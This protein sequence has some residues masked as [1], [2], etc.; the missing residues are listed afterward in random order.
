M[1]RAPC[2]IVLLSAL[3]LFLTGCRVEPEDP[4]I[5]EERAVSRPNI[6]IYLVDT[7]RAD[8]LG[9]YGYSRP[10][11]PN[12]DAFAAEATLFENAI[13]QSS[14]TRASMAS[15]FTGVWP[16]THGATG[17]KHPL[18]EEFDTLVESLDASGYQTAAFVG[19]P[20]LTMRYGFGQ[21]FDKFAREI[22]R[23]SADYND[24]V[25]EW[26]DGL[27]DDEPW[28]I[29]VH[30]M[31]PHAPYRPSEPYLSEFAPND[32]QM[33]SWK[34]R[35]KWPSEV[36]PFFSDRYDGEIAQN[37][38][39][40]GALL[41]ILQERGLYED[42]LVVFTSDHGEEFKEHGKW[43]YGENL[44]AETLN[45][46]LIV[47][48]PRQF[49]GRRVLPAVQHIDLMPTILDYVGLEIPD[50]VQG[51]SLVGRSELAGE[52]Y[53]HLFLSGFPL[54]HSVVVD[55]WKLI[56][57]VDEDGSQ[58]VQLFDWQKNPGE[59]LDLSAQQLERTASLLALLEAKLADDQEAQTGE[60]IPLTEE[61]Q[62][63]LEALG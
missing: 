1:S 51:R 40:F 15:L 46:P 2:S 39:S 52:I 42:A 48:L 3:S 37:D 14:W 19:N 61:L 63:E 57:R 56:R 27:T 25:A 23:P 13:G 32:D 58:T 8:R 41:G 5:G 20:Q 33:P 55:K 7:L 31:D 43:R 54:Y 47:R 4:V 30:T 44:H 28:F 35:W 21:G 11:S 17:W 10:T 60:E 45:V 12:I 18:P 22:K 50:R 16:P 36:L 53:S 49:S 29:Y 9:C 62:E 24:M 26:L 6:L 38:S 59:T 34:P